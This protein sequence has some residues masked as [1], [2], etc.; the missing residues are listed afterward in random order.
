MMDLRTYLQTDP[1]GLGL[2]D[3]I[4]QGRAADIALLLAATLRPSVGECSSN[5]RVGWST[6]W[7]VA[8]RLRVVMADAASLTTMVTLMPGAETSLYSVADGFARILSSSNPLTVADSE[9]QLYLAQLAALGID[10]A[11]KADLELR[12]TRQLPISQIQWGRIV[13]HSEISEA[14]R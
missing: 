14:L 2:A 1:D 13:T 8:G 10:P 6:R 12:A 5:R 9:T 7:N 3:L 11:A 4:A